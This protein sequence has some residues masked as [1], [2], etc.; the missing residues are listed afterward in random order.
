MKDVGKQGPRIVIRLTGIATAMAAAMPGTPALAQQAV[1]ASR[2]VQGLSPEIV[3]GIVAGIWLVLAAWAVAR[4]IRWATAANR[5]NHG[6]TRLKALLGASPAAYL[7]VA[8]DR[9]TAA[10][11]SFLALVGLQ[12]EPQTLDDL[13]S[14]QLRFRPDDIAA[15]L[16]EIASLPVSGR[17]FVVLLRSTVDRRILQAEGRIPSPELIGENGAVIW[18]SDVTDLQSDRDSLA[19]RASQLKGALS[20]YTALIEA[21]P[22]PIWHRDAA[23]ALELVNTSYVRAVEAVSASDAISRGA[24]LFDGARGAS[25]RDT[26]AKAQAENRTLVRTEPAIVEG[27]RRMFRV[28]DVPLGEA[29]VAGFAFDIED[30]EQIR[31]E[32]T[33]FSRAQ[34]ET[35]DRLSAGVAQFAAD[36]S[37]VFFNQPFARIFALDPDWLAERPEFDRV[38]ER[39]REQQRLPEQ[40]DF[41]SWR[42]ERRDWFLWADEAIEETWA[43]PEGSHLRVLAQPHPDGGLLLIFEDRTEQFRLASS[44]DTLL[45]VQAATLDNLFEAVCVFAANGRLQLWNSRFADMWGVKHADLEEHPAIDE[46]VPIAARTFALP[47]RAEM[48]KHFVRSATTDRRQR[49]GRLSLKDGRHLEFAAVPLPDGNAL[50]TMLDITDSRSIE[51]AL[52]DR[53]EALEAADRLKSAFVANMSYE[54]RTPLTSIIG[55]GEMLTG[56]YAGAL[57]A[58]QGEYIQ[59]ILTA[60]DR[61]QGL[62]DNILDLAISDA[63]ALELE[64]TPVDMKKLLEKAVADKH[65]AAADKALDLSLKVSANAGAV[66]GDERRLAATM[67]HLLSNSIAFTPAGG[68]VFVLAEGARDLV[69]ITVSDSGVGIAPED[70]EKVFS[71]FNRQEDGVGQSIGGL[72]LALVRRYLSLHGG[73]VELHSEL[74][75]GTTVVLKIPRRR[76]VH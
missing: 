20:S 24:E 40:R 33:R 42:N 51:A 29:G 58:Q 76:R 71:P 25:A 10:S 27:E 37:L 22:F 65:A 63:G 15:L 64:I 47:R 32:L 73:T 30:L 59:S 11:A 45:R 70:Q 8:K 18:F 44:R 56:G 35:L 49:S 6:N 34:R 13:R 14:L 28:F 68:R 48:I 3:I 52:R 75:Q 17:P 54:L 69:T 41:L 46:L 72:G 19:A 2:D 36:R 50:F 21:A 1:V 43:L 61:L 12:S 67:H 5:A 7:L 9:R 31:A 74:G 66:D 60:A 4:A 26:V 55:F 23:G 62:I 38:L 16:D 53:N 57:E 39:M